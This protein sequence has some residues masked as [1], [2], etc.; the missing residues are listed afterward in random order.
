MNETQ[1]DLK[2]LAIRLVG[3]FAKGMKINNVIVLAIGCP[4]YLAFIWCFLSFRLYTMF[5]ADEFIWK[6]TFDTQGHGLKLT[7]IA[8]SLM[9]LFVIWPICRILQLS[10]PETFEPSLESNDS[11]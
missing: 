3:W 8:C 6:S 2:S 7:L 10:W 1:K 9:S 11:D 5:E 4:V